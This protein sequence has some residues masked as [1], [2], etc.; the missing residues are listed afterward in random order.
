MSIFKRVEDLEHFRG[1]RALSMQTLPKSCSSAYNATV[2]WFLCVSL[3]RWPDAVVK[4]IAGWRGAWWHLEYM[5]DILCL[6]EW[7]RVE[8]ANEFWHNGWQFV[9]RLPERQDKW[10]YLDVSWYS[11]SLSCSGD[12][13]LCSRTII[14][15]SSTPLG[16]TDVVCG[17]TIFSNS[18]HVFRFYTL[19]L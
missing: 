2:L 4:R 16:A 12:D 6:A 9:L 5:Q 10:A 19:N 17:Y 7:K 18:F 11:R 1:I 3:L 14:T 8:L 13:F 15:A